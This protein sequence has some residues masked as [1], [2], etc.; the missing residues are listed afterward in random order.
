QELDGCDE[1][2]PAHFSGVTLTQVTLKDAAFLVFIEPWL[3]PLKWKPACVG[4]SGPDIDFGA[5]RTHGCLYL[6]TVCQSTE[7]EPCT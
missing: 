5:V 4:L 7:L 6:G 1:L 2:H 3:W